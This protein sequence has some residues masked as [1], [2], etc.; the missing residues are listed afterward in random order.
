MAVVRFGV[1]KGEVVESKVVLFEP[2]QF[3]VPVAQVADNEAVVLLHI[4]IPAAIG[5]VGFG[6]TVTFTCVLGLTQFGKPSVGDGLFSQ[7]AK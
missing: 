3:T 1:T 7:A 2:Y 6:F 4:V 5:A